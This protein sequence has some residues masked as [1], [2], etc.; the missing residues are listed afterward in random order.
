MTDPLG[1]SQVLPYIIGLSKEYQFTLISFEKAKPFETNQAHIQALCD[2]NNIVWKPLMYTKNPPVFSTVFDVI[3]LFK[4]TKKLHALSPFWAIHCRSYISALVGLSFKKKRGVKFI[5]DMRGFWAD[6]R[7]D[8][9]LW[10]LKNPIFKAVY[11][12][13]KKKERA[14]LQHADA[15]ISLTQK[16]KDEM[17]TWKITDLTASKICVIPCVTDFSLFEQVSDE[18]R[19]IAK[20]R[21]NLRDNQFVLLYLG[22]IGTWYL[23]D[24]MLE[25]FSKLHALNKDAKFLFLTNHSEDDIV[26]HAEKYKLNKD[27]LLVRFVQREHIASVAHAADFGIFF[28]QPA[29]S[30][31]ASSPTKMGEL[32]AMGIP[33]I[34]N[35]GVGNV[36]ELVL[37]T[38]SGYCIDEL[39][40]LAFE[41]T[42]NQMYQSKFSSDTIRS[43][44]ASYLDLQI[45]INKYQSVYSQ[46]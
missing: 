1:Q 18:S 20:A 37:Q 40:D 16:A 39:T 41:Q 5:F 44:A 24:E 7:V 8:G 46:V 3:K 33:L 42:I 4:L 34:C 43:N 31:M 13:F 38:E 9:N 2:A 6:E 45:G 17:L 23:L 11:S 10:N 14:Y 36:D 26:K 21:L 15:I 27:D 35:S 28:I 29:Y 19:R 12:F 25:F 30:K 32:L 22:S